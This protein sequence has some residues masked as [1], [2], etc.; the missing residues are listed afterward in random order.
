MD[1][2]SLSDSTTFAS[3][4]EQMIDVENI[5]DFELFLDVT[6]NGEGRNYNLFIARRSSIDAKFFLV[7]WDYDMSFWGEIKA[8]N[9]LIDR[10]HRDLPGYNERL[11]A[12]WQ[13]LRAGPLSEDRVISRVDEMYAQLAGGAADRNFRRW[14]NPDYP[15]EPYVEHLRAWLRKRL[16]TMD[17]NM[18]GIDTH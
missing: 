11:K 7:P 4:V 12:R 10:L 8:N 15:Y 16:A 14:P 13:Q 5:M 9:Y 2:I 17:W 18:G 3:R 1:F 6:C